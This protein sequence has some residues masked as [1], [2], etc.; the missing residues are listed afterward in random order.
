MGIVPCV[1]YEKPGSQ[2]V[3]DSIAPYCKDYNALL[4][5][6]HG[7]LS[8]GRTLIEAFYRLEAM[9]HYAMILMYTGHI[10]KK[11]NLLSKGQIEELR[12]IRE[13]LGISAG[14][15]PAGADHAANLED[16]ICND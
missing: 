7:A 5:G 11:A 14:G 16:V 10:I 8:W 2:G 3:P 15:I 1:H 9:E 13:S 6:N 12:E 4:L